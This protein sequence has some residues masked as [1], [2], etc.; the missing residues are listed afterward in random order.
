[1]TVFAEI[2]RITPVGTLMLWLPPTALALWVWFRMTARWLHLFQLSSYQH[3]SYRRRLREARGEVLCAPR[4]VLLPGV[5]L[6][7]VLPPLWGALCAVLCAALQLFCSPV[8]T[9]KGYVHPRR[10]VWLTLTVL[11]AAFALCAALG[12][13]LCLPAALA[14]ALGALLARFPVGV[15]AKIALVFTPRAKRLLVTGALCAAVPAAALWFLHPAC[16][17]AVL[18]LATLFQP[19]L[20]MAYNTL[21]A[22]REARIS[23]RFVDEARDKLRAMPRLTVIGITGSF[24]KTS[25]KQFLFGLLSTKYHTYMTPGNY[26]TTLG[27]TRAVREGLQP[28]HEIFLCEMGARHAGDI[29]E[30]CELAQPDLAVITAVGE[31]HLETFGSLDGVLRT[32]LELYDAVRG[33]G[34]A[35]FNCDSAPLAS[36]GLT[37]SVV[38]CGSGEGLDYTV[39][40]IFVDDN[41]SSFEIVPP[42]GEPMAFTTQLLGRAN[43]QNLTLSIA[44]AHHLGVPYERMRAAVRRLA[45]APHRLEMRRGGAYTII[46]DA[47]NANPV[48]ARNALETLSLCRGT[49]ILVT[50]GM[51][52]LG[53]RQDAL[54]REM[55]QYAAACCDV[56]VLIGRQAGVLREGLLAGN[57]PPERIHSFET[58]GQGLAFV[59]SVPGGR[60]RMVLLLNDLPD[61]YR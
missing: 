34:L 46:D 43:V 4:F 29:R 57:M 5:V 35:F 31:Q 21:N 47:Y 49:R 61:Q 45:P 22:P 9:Q 50:P 1:M 60:A 56:A 3:P 41:G 2:S 32:K 17:L 10:A 38:K 55:A 24:G 27:V 36:A 52:E 16:T 18:A 44:V 39:R 12:E 33:R 15:P 8:R 6:A 30:L 26:N 42:D 48:G 13:T 54:N 37:E 14:C 28:T 11:F 23:Q 19:W 53:D 25:V 51:V 7:F 59:A 20:L 58:I 40:N